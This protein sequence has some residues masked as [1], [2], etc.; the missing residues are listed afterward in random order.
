M[1]SSLIF[2]F[3]Y[4]LCLYLNGVVYLLLHYSCITIGFKLQYLPLIEQLINLALSFRLYLELDLLDHLLKLLDLGGFIS[5]IVNNELSAL[6][7]LQ[8]SVRFGAKFRFKLC[9]L[10]LQEFFLCFRGGT[11]FFIFELWF[12]GVLDLK[13]LM[14]GHFD[15]M[16]LNQ[17]LL[18]LEQVGI[19]VVFQEFNNEQR[20]CLFELWVGFVETLP[21]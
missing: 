19:V 9:D 17:W 7:G 11:L 6:S 10:M 15:R 16:M 20:L 2:F 14:H 13:L 18:C 3:Y 4:V 8:A 21:K 1:E 12:L 5:A